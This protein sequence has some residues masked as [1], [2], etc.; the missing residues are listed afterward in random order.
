LVT[1]SGTAKRT[2]VDVKGGQHPV[3]D[4]EL[5][6]P[7][8]TNTAEKYRKLEVACYCKEHKSEDLL[9][10]GSVDITETLKTGEFDGRCKPSHR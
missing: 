9:G 7:V 2:Q 4:A 3:W 1:K 6:F 8:L 10:S 5:R